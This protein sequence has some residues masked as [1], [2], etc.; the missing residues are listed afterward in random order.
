V[1]A[2]RYDA[3]SADGGSVS[4]VIESDSARQARA[5]LRD[6]GLLPIT[7]DPVSDA[8]LTRG[9]A[10]ATRRTVFGPY[11][12]ALI[13]RQ[14]AT[15]LDAGLTVEHALTA[16]ADQCATRAERETLAA[17]R[18]DVL[19]GM[20]LS[21]A[22]GNAGF[23][24]LYCA[25]IAAGERSG[26]LTTV[27]GKL[28]DYLERRHD[29]RSRVLHALIYPAVVAMVAMAVVA[30]L[31]GYVVP[32]LI[33]VFES[34]RQV[35]PWPTRALI[36]V[37]NF[38]RTT[39]WLWLAGI[40]TL[41]AGYAWARR[42]PGLHERVQA[43][44]LRLPLVGN[45]LLLADSA[46]FASAL[47]ILSASAVPILAALEAAQATLVSIPLRRA[48]ATAAQAVGEGVPLS[49]A[50]KAAGRFPPLIIHLIANG[51][52]T[53]SLDKALDAATRAAESELNGRTNVAMALIE[54]ALIVTLGLFVLA[55]VIAVL[56]PVIEINQLLAPR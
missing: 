45:M 2:F 7:V 48:V 51:E 21:A 41:V 22:F 20:S 49:A 38:V 46:R 54:P 5:Q 42:V 1:T 17:V 6:R 32:Q 52:A 9:K 29:T 53:G 28:A 4:G 25:L 37:S 15:M 27:I 19:A 3:V 47:S 12:L 14:F 24:P 44:A 40:A 10:I 34:T 26:R 11:Q 36:A 16:V 8:D 35:L 31:L 50:L 43:L 23:A 13:T 30:A 33:A 39:W 56:L 18:S 55:V